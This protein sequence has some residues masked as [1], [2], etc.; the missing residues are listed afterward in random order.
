MSEH[1]SDTERWLI[2]QR[3][4]SEHRIAEVFKYFRS[5]NIEPILI[6]GWAAGLK[7]SRPWERTFSDLDLAVDPFEYLRALELLDKKY[8]MV[9]LHR[10]LRQHDTLEWKNLYENSQVVKLENTEI[11]VLREEDHLRVL[12]VHWLIDGGA[13]KKK[14]LDVY[15]AVKNRSEN[16]DWQRCLDSVTDRRR[17]WV[18][19]TIGLAH[20]YYQLKIDDLPFAREAESIPVW[21]IAALEKEWKTDVRLMPLDQCLSDK[22]MLWQQILK[23]IPP[24]PIQATI[25]MEGDFDARTRIFYQLGSVKT[26]LAPSLRRLLKRIRANS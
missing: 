23:R 20:R 26:R 22:N 7:Y 4:L 5:F 11:R 9:D 12:C 10:G 16:F 14:L 1:N 25:E 3:K 8:L 18:I 6:K 15:Y 17:K 13:Y 2:L 21:L 19:Y 24:N